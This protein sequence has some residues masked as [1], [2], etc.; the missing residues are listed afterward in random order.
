MRVK[1]EPCPCGHCKQWIVTPLFGAA[2]ASMSREDADE[3][4]RRWNSFETDEPETSGSN[5]E[6]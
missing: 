1:V 2:E 3:L 4:A 5:G 6:P